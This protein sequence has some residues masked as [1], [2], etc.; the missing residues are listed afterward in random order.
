[1]L[2]EEMF[3]DHFWR[4]TVIE[5]TF[6]GHSKKE[7]RKRKKNR[8]VDEEKMAHMM[9]D[10]LT[11]LFNLKHEVPLVFVD[12]VFEEDEYDEYEYDEEDEEAIAFKQETKKLWRLI[13]KADK[14]D[15]EGGCNAPG[16]L[17][18]FPMLVDARPVLDRIGGKVSITWNIWFGDCDQKGVRSYDILHD[19]RKIYRLN[20]EQGVKKESKGK[21]FPINVVVN[22]E[23]SHEKIIGTCDNSRSKYKIV[24]L[25]FH[26]LSKDEFGNY[27]VANENGKSNEVEIK[28]IIDGTYTDWSIWGPCSKTCVP[29][30]GLFGSMQRTRKCLEPQNGGNECEGPPIETKLCANKPGEGGAPRY[31]H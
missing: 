3:G 29:L 23:C 19:G 22:D 1:M 28:E 14:F 27:S 4:N 30:D 11:R 26:S 13:N 31:L 10:E 5:V 24:T 20:D 8:K 15:C 21:D 17:K 7:K 6:W 18:G 9:N 12:P 25:T 2:Y 16:F